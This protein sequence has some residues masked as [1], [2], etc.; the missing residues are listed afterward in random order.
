MLQDKYLVCTEKECGTEFL[1][2]VKDQEFFKSKGFGDPKRCPSCRKA[3]K[4]RM[5]SPFAKVQREVRG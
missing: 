2:S 4:R 3:K 5:N 1:F